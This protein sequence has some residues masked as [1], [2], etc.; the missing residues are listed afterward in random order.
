MR[1][2]SRCILEPTHLSYS[3][4]NQ[5][6]LGFGETKQDFLNSYTKHVFFLAK[7]G[8]YDRKD[9]SSVA[10]SLSPEAS[11]LLGLED[12]CLDFTFQK[13]QNHLV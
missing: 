4:T 2:A 3:T 5:C 12:F 9:P 10:V 6:H 8:R 1:R 13:P 11:L 7:N